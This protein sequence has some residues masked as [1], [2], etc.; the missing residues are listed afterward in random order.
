MTVPIPLTP[1]TVAAPNTSYILAQS[2]ERL[3]FMPAFNDTITVTGSGDT[4]ILNNSAIDTI[5]LGPN[6]H[7]DTLVFENMIYGDSV[8]GWDKSDSLWLIS[9][10]NPHLTH[11]TA[12]TSH[13]F[14]EAP[15]GGIFD[16]S[17]GFSGPLQP[18]QE[19]ILFAS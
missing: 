6:S 11:I 2:W 3:S 7:G 14:I 5:A 19:H 10:P 18:W 9:P 15:P 16:S 13:L 4:L 17:I 8:T 1:N 12:P